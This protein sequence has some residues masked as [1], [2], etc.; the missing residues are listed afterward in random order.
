M[1]KA[2]DFM[3]NRLSEV[4][5]EAEHVQFEHDERMRNRERKRILTRGDREANVLRAVLSILRLDRRVAWAARMNSGAFVMENRYVRFGARG[6]PDI[7]GYTTEGRFLAIECKR[8]AGKATKNQREFMEAC[9]KSGC[10]V[11]IAR[12]AQDAIDILNGETPG[13]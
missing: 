10:L 11:G 13:L 7:I 2:S 1:L 8:A 9:K 12:N 4:K 5:A 3:A 6:L